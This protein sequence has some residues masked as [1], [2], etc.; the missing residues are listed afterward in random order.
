VASQL[1]IL[2]QIEDLQLAAEQRRLRTVSNAEAEVGSGGTEVRLSVL[3]A[4]RSRF[5][6]AYNGPYLEPSIRRRRRRM[7]HLTTAAS[8][9]TRIGNG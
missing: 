4:M 6:S 1:C 2:R 5:T 9:P 8:P 3:L 7:N